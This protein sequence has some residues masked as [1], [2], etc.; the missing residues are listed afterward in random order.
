VIGRCYD[1]KRQIE[2]IDFLEVLNPVAVTVVHVVLD[3]VRVHK[4]KPVLAR[5]ALHPRFV[6]FHF[7]LVHGSWIN[8]VEQCFGVVTRKRL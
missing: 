8:Q 4:G 7:T 5:L 2:L 1:H 3:N 6:F